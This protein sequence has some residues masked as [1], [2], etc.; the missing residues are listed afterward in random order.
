M[1]YDDGWFAR[2][3][4]PHQNARPWRGF[5]S[6]YDSIYQERYRSWGG[7]PGGGQ[8]RYDRE[9]R[10]SHPTERPAN[11]PPPHWGGVRP[12]ERDY[13]RGYRTSRGGPGRGPGGFFRGG[14]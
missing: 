14:F 6:G 11:F 1:R 4:R 12:R 7:A 13:D 9:W 5:R 3:P 10:G 8:Y 2:G